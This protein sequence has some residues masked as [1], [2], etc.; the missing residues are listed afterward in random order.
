MG[1][2]VGGSDGSGGPGF[3]ALN[4]DTPNSLADFQK[5]EAIACTIL[6]SIEALPHNPA[7]HTDATR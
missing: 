5:R 6:R 7:A 1:E 4:V 2:W 3:F